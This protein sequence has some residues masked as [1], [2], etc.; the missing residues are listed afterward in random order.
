MCR[1]VLHH[2][3]VEVHPDLVPAT[4]EFYSE[5]IGL[6]RVTSMIQHSMWFEQGV[7]LYWGP[8]RGYQDEVPPPRHFALVVGAGYEGIRRRCKQMRL[9]LTDGT[10][11]WGSRR[12]YVRDPAGNRVE[13]MET[14]P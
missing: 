1:P 3:T 6:S 14:A 9:F 13:L 5:V 2:V 8:Q 4:Q 12:C 7:H 11:Y 10:E